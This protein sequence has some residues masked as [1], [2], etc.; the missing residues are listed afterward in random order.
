MQ[1]AK[2]CDLSFWFLLRIF[3]ENNRIVSL[4]YTERSFES[5]IVPERGS[6]AENWN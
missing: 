3:N 1:K 2:I 6:Y 4:I 5:L